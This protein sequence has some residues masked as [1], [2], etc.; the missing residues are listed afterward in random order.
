[1]FSWK[2]IRD[3]TWLTI[4]AL[5]FYLAGILTPV[6]GGSYPYEECETVAVAT[7][8][9]GLVV[10]VVGDGGL[11]AIPLKNVIQ[12]KWRP[13]N[14]QYVVWKFTGEPIIVP[15]SF[16]LD[17]IDVARQGGCES[18]AMPAPKQ[19]KQ[20]EEILPPSK[21]RPQRGI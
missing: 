16:M 17:I 19:E 9:C 11:S 4:F 8:P 13:K 12:V 14:R 5:A 18:G 7:S 15:G 1:M 2:K 21:L 3:I 10:V 6:S 20:D